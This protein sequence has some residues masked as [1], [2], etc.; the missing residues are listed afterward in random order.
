MD[1]LLTMHAFVFYGLA[2]VGLI[3]HALVRWA[4][5]Q[6]EGG[7]PDW[8]LVNKKATV[9]AF[10]LAEGAVAGLILSGQIHDP[11][12]AADILQVWGVSYFMDSAFNNQKV[13]DVKPEAK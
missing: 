12:A 9:R 11:N 13:P 7:V 3:A 5:G 4:N 6:I 1:K 2:I 8:F 10:I